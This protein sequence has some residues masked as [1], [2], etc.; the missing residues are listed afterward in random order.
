MLGHWH[1][2]GFVLKDRHGTYYLVGNDCARTHFGLDW[3]TFERSVDATLDRQNDL[4]WI[5]RT[6]KL[7]LGFSARLEEIIEHP[8]VSAFDRL[9]IEVRQM[10]ERPYSVFAHASD[11]DHG[12][13]RGTFWERDTFAE[14]KRLDTEIEKRSKKRARGN[15][16]TAE[17]TRIKNEFSKRPILL[18]VN[19]QVVRCLAPTL[20]RQNFKMRDR[21]QSIWLRLS[22][23]ATEVGR[24]NY[25]GRISDIRTSMTRTIK[26]FDAVLAELENASAMFANA[27]LQ[28]LSVIFDADEFKCHN[29]ATLA[30]GFSFDNEQ[31]RRLSVVAPEG[32]MPMK[33]SLWDEVRDAIEP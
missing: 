29:F 23:Q 19:K 20:F 10:P 16:S 2:R 22:A 1:N 31:G 28:K 21:L 24:G 30:K 12:W 8:S 14:R 25:A 15:L 11:H 33:F 13:L 27:H 7:I 17:V 9:R 32:L 26:D 4:L 3:V 18:D 5:G 6:S